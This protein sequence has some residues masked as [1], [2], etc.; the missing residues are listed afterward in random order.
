M[1]ERYKMFRRK[2]GKFYLRDTLTRAKESLRTADR[3]EASRLLAAKNQSVEQPCLNRAM[4]KTYLSASS[5]EFASRSWGD[6]ID[7]YVASG[8]ESSRARKA[9]VFRSRP[10]LAL[11][12]IR[13]IDTTAE[14][15]LAVMEHRKAGNSTTHYTRRLHNYAVDLGWLLA[16][17]MAPAIWP[18]VK[19]KKFTAILQSEHEQIVAVETRTDFCN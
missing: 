6:V 16:P 2:G 9:R 10:Y 19:S 12:K 7:R 13:L 4:A 17:V 14:D 18:K 8:A 11:R 3:V 1:K 5:P 15:L